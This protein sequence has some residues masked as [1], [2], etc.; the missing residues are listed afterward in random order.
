MADAEKAKK[1]AEDEKERADK[2]A[3]EIQQKFEELKSANTEKIASMLLQGK[4]YLQK[5]AYDSAFIICQTIHNIPGG[6]ENA[7]RFISELL[8]FYSESGQFEKA[9]ELLSMAGQGS[10]HANR[11]SITELLKGW[12]SGFFDTLTLRYY[13]EMIHVEKGLFL[14]GADLD[15]DGK[16]D[17]DAPLHYEAVKQFWTREN[18]NHQ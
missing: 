14:M 18:R 16:I 10:I 4:R 8:Y 13:P 1:K 9:A 3:A 12:N 2:L 6:R 5:M 11:G 17:E 7:R 15:R